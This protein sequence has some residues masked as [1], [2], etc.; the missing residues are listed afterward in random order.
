MCSLCSGS[1]IL[2]ADLGRSAVGR[3]VVLA[4]IPFDFSCGAMAKVLGANQR[5]SL[6]EKASTKIVGMCQWRGVKNLSGVVGGRGV[7]DGPASKDVSRLRRSGLLSV[8]YPARR[9]AAG[10]AIF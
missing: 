10:W 6:R 9:K 4:G 1:G 8:V 7:C 2:G 5:N 3:L